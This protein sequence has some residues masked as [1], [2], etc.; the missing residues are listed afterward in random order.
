MTGAQK[1][2]QGRCALVTGASRGLG[3]EIARQYLQ[4]GANVM[5]CAR[6]A[7]ALEQAGSELRAVALSGQI[8]LAQAADISRQQDVGAVVER[9][10]REFGRLDVV[11]NN[12]AIVGPA[13]A[14]EDVDWGRWV[15]AIEVNLLGAV[16]VSRAVL[17][18]FKRA[19]Y[20]KIIQLSGGGA[21]NPLP[22]LSAYAASKAGVIRFMES[23]AEETRNYHIDVNAI[24]PGALDTHMLDEFIGAGPELV[25]RAFHERCVRLKQQGCVPLSRGGALAV[26]LGSAASDGITGKLL[27]AAWDPWESLAQRAADLRSTDVYTLRRIVPADRDLSWGARD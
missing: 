5:I 25:G 14:S 2:L 10:L 20:G 4:A 17:P 21:T 9:A 22:M 18:A 3:L 13:G 15:R 23:L 16:L 19:G 26:F 7:A 24:A 11:V 8:L 6:G 1:V 27:S 12:A